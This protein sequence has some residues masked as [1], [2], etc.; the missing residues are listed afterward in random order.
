MSST[1]ANL[2][3]E[4]L[5]YAF[6]GYVSHKVTAA[7]EPQKEIRKDMYDLDLQNLKFSVNE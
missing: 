2:D 4:E 5:V 6:A 3:I 1:I 7:P